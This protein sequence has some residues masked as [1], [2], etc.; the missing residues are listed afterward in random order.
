[1]LP[2]RLLPLCVLTVGL[3][4]LPAP[5]Q[6][7]FVTVDVPDFCRPFEQ[8]SQADGAR[9][10][11]FE[12]WDPS[13][14]S[15]DANQ[16][17]ILSYQGNN[18][19]EVLIQGRDQTG[20]WVDS[21]RALGSYDGADRITECII[22][23][24]QSGLLVNALRSTFSYNTNGQLDV[25]VSQRW[26]TTAASPNGTWINSSRSTYSYDGSGNVTQRFDE[27]W[28]P[29]TDMWMDTRRLQ[30]T[31]DGSNRLTVR[32]EEQPDGSGGWLN[33]RRTQNTYGPDGLEE[34]LVEDWNLGFQTWE[35]EERTLFSSPSSDTR[36]D[37]DQTWNGTTWVN[38]ERT[39]TTLNA[40]DLPLTIIAEEWSGST[41]VNID[42]TE[43]SYTTINS[44]EKLEQILE[45][46]WDDG[47]STW[48]ND[49]RLLISYTDVI[50]VE[51]ASF[52]AWTDENRAVLHWQTSSE[53][54]NAGFELQHRVSGEAAWTVRDFIESAVNGGTTSEP[55]SYRVRTGPLT[56]GLHDFRLRQVDLDGTSTLTDPVSVQIRMARAVRLLPP[57]PNP[58]TDRATIS[59]AVDGTENAVVALYNLLGQR[60]RTLYRGAVAPG[61]EQ[62]IEFD[63]QDLPS[64]TYLLR[65]RAGGQTQTQRL[66]VVR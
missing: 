26:D 2:S 13:T 66:T 10:A 8:F 39:S 16:R 44:A 31:Y 23:T 41:W 45:Q 3:L 47:T 60:V 52:E 65:L 43:N 42:R 51:L 14:P 27:T 12:E 53:T 25:E 17:W 37:V 28:N 54:N 6:A 59:F 15:W 5:A 34:T 57:S 35:N 21:S 56:P 33:D 29:N 30:N 11:L 7:Q 40:S 58:I 38:E 24:R 61:L 4:L 20:A 55:Q 64:G 62:E 63:A 49:N 48:I 1:M 9:S 19:T 22:Q 32:L 46:S 36:V 50:P 18:P